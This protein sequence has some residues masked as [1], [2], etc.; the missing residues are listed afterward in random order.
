MI[1]YLKLNNWKAFIEEKEFHFKD[2]ITFITGINGSGKTSILEGI[3]TALTGKA[4]SSSDPLSSVRNSNIPS[5]IELMFII[6]GKTYI[7]NRIFKSGRKTAFLKM[8]EKNTKIIGWNQV[9]Q[10]ILELMKVDELFFSRLVYMAEGE[11]Y[12]YLNDPPKKAISS[13]IKDIF[14]IENLD[15]ISKIFH[16]NRTYFSNLTDDIRDRI[17]KISEIKGLDNKIIETL[18]NE[19]KKLREQKNNAIKDLEKNKKE[20]DNIDYRKKNVQ[21]LLEII[22]SLEKELHTSGF[23]KQS[24]KLSIDKLD[25]PIT[26]LEERIKSIEKE[27]S[28]INKNIGALQSNISYLCDI[29][30]MLID[31]STSPDIKKKVLCPVCKRPIDEEMA[32]KLLSGVEKE[33]NNAKINLNNTNKDLKKLMIVQQNFKKNLVSLNEHRL[34]IKQIPKE[35]I[36][37]FP[38]LDKI[39]IKKKFL[40]LEEKIKDL[41]NRAKSLSQLSEELSKKIEE[42]IEKISTAKSELRQLGLRSDLESKI[43][44]TYKGEII[45]EHIE[46][47]L[48]SAVIQQRDNYLIPIYNN[49]AELWNRFK[50]EASWQIGFEEDGTMYLKENGK[51]I[52]F[53]QLSGG[54]KTVLLVLARVIICKSL[55]DVNFLM[56]DE[57]L[58]HLDIRNRRSLLNFLVEANKKRVIPQLLISTFEETLIRKFYKD[59]NIHFI[60]LHK[61][62]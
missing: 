40:R 61:E 58:E 20:R 45:S 30:K 52:Y 49:I 51:S 6:N 5:Q 43:I 35:I 7:V 34:E 36:E 23:I 56:I 22:I 17:Q 33:L 54:E 47:A 3:S 55:S 18:E 11:V 2:G 53:N 46:K 4:L 42:K 27:I 59:Q 50:P 14:G 62:K 26:T 15:N 57:P 48:Q 25:M 32:K 44:A 8:H 10:K 41:D 21:R 13:R 19:L 9:S 1:T 38:F 29:Q 12:N 39:F 37:S 31:I 16:E 28:E 24:E 60:Y